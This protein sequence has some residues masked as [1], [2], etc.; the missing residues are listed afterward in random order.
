MVGAQRVTPRPVAPRVTIS[1]RRV[2]Q[3]LKGTVRV[4]VACP[5][6]VTSCRVTLTLKVGART[7]G[8]TTLTVRGNTSRVAA[9][10]LSAW[11]RRTLKARRTLNATAV[12]TSRAPAGTSV[13]TRTHIQLLAPKRQAR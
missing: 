4:R 5:K 10:R 9:V 3:S 11:A 2:R 8:R 6:G 12:A 1:P 13:T 7:V